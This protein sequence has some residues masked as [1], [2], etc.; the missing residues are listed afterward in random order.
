MMCF[1]LTRTPRERG[2]HSQR[3]G[4]EVALWFMGSRRKLV[5][6][7]DGL[8]GGPPALRAATGSN[9]F[10][11]FPTISNQFQSIPITFKKM[12]R[13]QYG[14][15][16]CDSRWTKGSVVRGSN[17]CPGLKV[18]AAQAN[19]V[20]ARH[21]PPPVRRRILTLPPISRALWNAKL[22]IGAGGTI[23]EPAGAVP[24]APGGRVRMRPRPLAGEI[25]LCLWRFLGYPVVS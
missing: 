8:A 14:F 5:G 4:K 13:R 24:G 19:N 23:Y 25:C 2:K 7:A 10:Q 18:P 12:M 22:R 16:M 15:W 17:G 21:C 3:L 1:T 9:D 6:Q 20:A 11:R